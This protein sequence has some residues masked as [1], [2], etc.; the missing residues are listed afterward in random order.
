VVAAGTATDEF[1]EAFI[2]AI[3]AHRHPT[4]ELGAIPA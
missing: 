2:E 3:A 1:I 4:R